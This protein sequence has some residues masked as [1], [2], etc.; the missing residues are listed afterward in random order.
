M[1][2]GNTKI[3]DAI[4][5]SF[6]MF[7]NPHLTATED[8]PTTTPLPASDKDTGKDKAITIRRKTSEPLTTANMSLDELK[9]RRIARVEGA[10]NLV[11]SFHVK[12]FLRFLDGL[13]LIGPFWILIFTTSEV[14][15]LFTGKGF[16]WQD[17]TSVNMYATALFGECI[18][19]GLTFLWQYALAYRNGLDVGTGEYQQVSKLIRGAGWTWL[20]FAG[21]SALGQAYYL[22]TIW[23]AGGW[24][25]Y[26]LIGGRVTLYTAGDWA[27]A[28]YLGWR[29]TSLRKIAQEEKAKG[30]VYQEM[31]RQEAQ[32][33][34]IEKQSDQEMKSIDIAIASQDRA[35]NAA[36]NVQDIMSKAAEKFLGRFTKTIDNVMNS[37]LASV[38]D[39]LAPGA[40][41]EFKELDGPDSGAL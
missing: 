41:A 15:Q 30:E 33:R 38:N 23:T 10:S 9:A 16:N 34:K 29:V 11:E 13:C 32:R 24:W 40:D 36:N 39:R 7:Y 31:A 4:G 5:R 1:A 22:H 8:Q 21:V 6:G 25:S 12:V 2:K 37:A 35:A 27:C 17:Q 28:K 19:A 18:L 14:G 3:K 20:L 26:L